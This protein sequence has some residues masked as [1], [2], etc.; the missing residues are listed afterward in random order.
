MTTSQYFRLIT[1]EL[2]FH[3]S[4][5]WLLI[6]EAQIIFCDEN[7]WQ[8]F[9]IRKNFVAVAS[10]SYKGDSFNATPIEF[11]QIFYLKDISVSYEEVEELVALY[12][13]INKLPGTFNCICTSMIFNKCSVPNPI[14]FVTSH[15]GLVDQCLNEISKRFPYD[16]FTCSEQEII[17][18]IIVGLFECIHRL[19][20]FI[21]FSALRSDFKK[22]ILIKSGTYGTYMHSITDVIL[23]LLGEST[24]MLTA[25]EESLEIKFL[26]RWGVLSIVKAHTVSFSS[27]LMLTYYRQQHILD[28]S[29]IKMNLIPNIKKINLV[30]FLFIVAKQLSKSALLNPTLESAT[31]K[32]RI[33]EISIQDEFYLR[34]HEVLPFTHPISSEVGYHFGISGS[35]CFIKC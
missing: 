9:K 23:D 17:K 35:S 25:F 6:D 19:R 7:F 34:T 33:E 27:N 14:G 29:R 32:L 31:G 10:Y 13:D 5:T 22:F 26:V 11:H 24:G 20:C 21:P 1:N 16:H 28:F 30:N 8:M 4:D 3:S 2:N 15:L 18:F 12:K